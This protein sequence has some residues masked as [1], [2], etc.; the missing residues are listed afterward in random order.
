MPEFT[1]RDPTS[2]KTLTVRGDSPPSE[3]E[4][5]ELFA[6]ADQPQA[7][8]EAAPPT[9]HPNQQLYD[10]MQGIGK[11][12]AR[13]IGGAFMGPGGVDAADH[14]G[15][16]LASAAVPV[17][18]QK[19]PGLM[20]RGLGVS[21]ARAA[22]NLEEAATAAKGVPINTEQV[23]QQGLRAMDLQATGARMPRAATQFMR[24]VTDPEQGAMPFEEARDF[25]SNLSRL[26][27]NEYGS[28]NPTMQRQIALMKQA[29]HEALTEGAESVGKGGQYASGIK[30]YARAA[31]FASG[32]K[33][34]GKAAAKYAVPTLGLGALGK[35]A[36]DMVPSH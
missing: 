35:Y 8:H 6:S 5:I 11:W 25:Y 13:A 32:A 16:T 4:L 2:G 19:V 9:P 31:K 7:S 17:A 30:E 23:G 33:S 26:S 18:I 28:L 22:Q 21:S 12:A 20:A 24:R 3:Q 27:A 10:Q 36:I 15:M 29:L 1:I 14:P 34:A